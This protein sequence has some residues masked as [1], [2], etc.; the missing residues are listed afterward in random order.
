[1]DTKTV[2]IRSAKDGAELVLS[3]ADY[4]ASDRMDVSIIG[5]AVSAKLSTSTY[6]VGSPAL[7]FE[8]MAK[9]WRGWEGEYRWATLEDD[10]RLAATTDRLGHVELSIVMK[11]ESCPRDWEVRVRIVLEAGVLDDIFRKVK[12]VFPIHEGA[13]RD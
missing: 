13:P 5:P 11:S 7:F 12:E 2:T 3:A 9:N 6:H 1:M 8:R 4:P 10:F